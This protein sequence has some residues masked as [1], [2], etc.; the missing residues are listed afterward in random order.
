MYKVVS[1]FKDKDG[2]FYN[3]GD[4]YPVAGVKKP[5]AERIKV[6]LSTNNAYDKVFIKKITQPKTDK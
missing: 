5:S 2:H 4:L 6:L 3:E 1:S